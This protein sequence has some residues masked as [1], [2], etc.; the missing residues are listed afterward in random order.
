M[1][2]FEKIDQFE[3]L[4]NELL[5]QTET[6]IDNAQDAETIEEYLNGHLERQAASQN[7][8]KKL[9]SLLRK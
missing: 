3:K 8:M 2:L 6:D 9:A 5:D 7:R 1:D 4:A